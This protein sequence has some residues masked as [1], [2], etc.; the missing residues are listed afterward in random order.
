MILSSIPK[1]TNLF[2]KLFAK[3]LIFERLVRVGHAIAGTASAV[4]LA[5]QWRE[6][7]ASAV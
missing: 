6:L 2:P 3:N 5:P 4:T 1:M 7:A